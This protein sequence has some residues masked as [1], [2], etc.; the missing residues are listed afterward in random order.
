MVSR[1]LVP[2][3][4][5]EADIPKR[6]SAMAVNAMRSTSFAVFQDDWFGDGNVPGS[7]STGG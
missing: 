2:V 4:S 3:E 5:P 7:S 6:G 1:G